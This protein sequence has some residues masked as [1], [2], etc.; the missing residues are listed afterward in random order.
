MRLILFISISIILFSCKKAEDRTCW[1]SAG[2][3]TKLEVSLESFDK[4]FL[5]EH[6]VYELVQDSLNKLVITGGDRKSVV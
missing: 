3:E 5:R 4:L 2:D 1:K 6:I